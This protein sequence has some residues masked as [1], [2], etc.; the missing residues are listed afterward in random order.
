MIVNI[1]TK[2]KH[3]EQPTS[4][5]TDSR[6][7]AGSS[8]WTS[9]PLDD[10]DLGGDLVTLGGLGSQVPRPGAVKVEGNYLVYDALKGAPGTDTFTYRV[11]DRFGAE[12]EGLVRVGVVPP[13]AVNQTSVAVADEVAARSSTRPGIPILAND[14]DPDGDQLQLVKGPAA[15]T[16]DSWDPEA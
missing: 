5:Q 4:K 16:D 9:V 7:F 13:P 8:V 3:N 1:C 2:D 15:A 10:I 11:L 14:I 6:T 12:G